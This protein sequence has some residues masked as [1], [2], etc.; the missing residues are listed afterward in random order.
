MLFLSDSRVVVGAMSKGRSSSKQLNYELRRCCG[1]AL[2]RGLTIDL[3]WIPTWGNPADAPSRG[4]PLKKWRCALPE[5]LGD[6]FPVVAA[7]SDFDKW[8]RLLGSS[9]AY[10]PM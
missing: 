8:C 10:D 4:V 1:V 9:S 5:G 6:P 3:V 7:P 2:R